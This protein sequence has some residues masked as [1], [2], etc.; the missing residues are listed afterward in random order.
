MYGCNNICVVG[1]LQV[2]RSIVFSGPTTAAQQLLI[3][4][5]IEEFFF[6][7]HVLKISKHTSNIETSK[8]LVENEDKLLIVFCNCCFSD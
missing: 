8:E 4:T 7:E 2:N 6:F 5:L 3:F 1:H